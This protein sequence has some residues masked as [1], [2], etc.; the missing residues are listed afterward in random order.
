[1]VQLSMSQQRPTIIGFTAILMWAALAVLTKL[2]GPI[3]P[4]QLT[5]MSFTIAFLIGVVI[6]MRDGGNLIGH[7]KLP[8]VVWALGIVGL[9][10]YHFFYFMALQNAPAVEAS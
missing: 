8:G 5:A 7:L 9:F 1:M 4:F 2:I 10:G 3:P 6:W